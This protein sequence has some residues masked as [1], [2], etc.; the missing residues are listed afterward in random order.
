MKNIDE[1]VKWLGREDNRNFYDE[2]QY[3]DYTLNYVGMFARDLASLI[4]KF[5]EENKLSDEDIEKNAEEYSYDVFSSRPI[6]C[7]PTDEEIKNAYIAGA[8][9]SIEEA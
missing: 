6:G 4:I 5:N 9:G 1:I 7:E 3:F 2:G 8:K